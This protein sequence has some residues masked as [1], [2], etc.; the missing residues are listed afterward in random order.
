MSVFGAHA[1]GE[2]TPVAG[3]DQHRSM[4]TILI[5]ACSTARDAFDPAGSGVDSE[6]VA[7]LERVIERAQRLLDGMGGS[8]V[9][10]PLQGVQS[11]PR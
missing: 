2:D 8:P 11:E 3:L 1:D 4:L 7:D 6:L 9:A 5:S 10:E